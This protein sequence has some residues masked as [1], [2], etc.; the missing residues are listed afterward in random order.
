M[1]KRGV[2]ACY[3]ILMAVACL[4]DRLEESL[5]PFSEAAEPSECALD[6][7]VDGLVASGSRW[8]CGLGS[9]EADSCWQRCVLHRYHLSETLT[10]DRS[11]QQLLSRLG[12]REQF[13]TKHLK[14]QLR[15]VTVGFSCNI[16][17]CEV[18]LISLTTLASQISQTEIQAW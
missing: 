7:F 18:E 8:G 5:L 13:G 16:S 9:E 11:L 1:V 14:M 2:R 12:T 6:Y 17:R 10:S 15:C 3:V 4:S